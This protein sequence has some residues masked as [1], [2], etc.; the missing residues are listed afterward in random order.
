LAASCNA[1]HFIESALADPW[2]NSGLPE[3]AKAPPDRFGSS[4]LADM[5]LMAP[6]IARAPLPNR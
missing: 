6:L 4:L 2:P 1:D 3:R 5:L